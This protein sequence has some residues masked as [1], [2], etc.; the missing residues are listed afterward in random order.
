MELIPEGDPDY[1]FSNDEMSLIEMLSLAC[2]L[3]ADVHHLFV[4][5][6]CSFVCY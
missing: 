5:R 6:P 4:Q 2:K 1:I 3:S